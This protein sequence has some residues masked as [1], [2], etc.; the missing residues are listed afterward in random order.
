MG[1]SERVYYMYTSGTTGQPK[2]VMVTNRN[3]LRLVRNT[4]YVPLNCKTKMILGGSLAFDASTFEIWG[5]LL[6]G[7]TV[8]IPST[9]TFVNK[10]KLKL[11]IHNNG[12]NTMWLTSSLF[13]QMIEADHKLFCE[14]D[15][16]LVGGEKLSKQHVE[17]FMENNS[18]TILINGYGPTENTTFTTTYQIPRDFQTIYIGKP[19]ANTQVYIMQ[20][21]TLCGIGV[22]GELCTS[23]DGVAKGYL[24]NLELTQDKF[25]SNPFGEGKMYRTGDIARFLSD[26]NIEYGGRVDSQVKIR[27]F[28]VELSGIQQ[29][30]ETYPGITRAVVI[31]SAEKRIE[32]ILCG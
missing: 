6:N 3:I 32:S 4:N 21:N 20:N 10:T 2:A 30:M 25:V 11:F 27:G 5:A 28:R 16:L 13:N 22:W 26:G 23:G 18:N 7:G 24:N 31:A 14:L 29:I 1:G 17:I 19:I 12:I 9:D 8:F 15:Y